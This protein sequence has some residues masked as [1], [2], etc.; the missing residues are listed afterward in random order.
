VLLDGQEENSPGLKTYSASPMK[1]SK[2]K[3]S[4]Q[5]LFDSTSTNDESMLQYARRLD[6]TG[7]RDNYEVEAIKEIRTSCNLIDAITNGSRV[8][9]LGS[10]N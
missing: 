4:E 6:T 10:G 8:R 9:Q 1:V 7:R 3:I 2:S 5:S